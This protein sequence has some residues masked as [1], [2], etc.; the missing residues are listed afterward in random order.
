MTYGIWTFKRKGKKFGSTD[1]LSRSRLDCDI[2]V[3][4][5]FICRTV[6]RLW[7]SPVDSKKSYLKYRDPSARSLR[8]THSTRT[9]LEAYHAL[10]RPTTFEASVRLTCS[11]NFVVVVVVFV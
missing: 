3:E 5:H 9:G 11:Y 7:R 2:I 8:H 4:D 1:I 10:T 6:S